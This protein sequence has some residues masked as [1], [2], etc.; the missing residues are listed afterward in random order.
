MTDIDKNG[1]LKRNISLGFVSK[2]ASVI[3]S[4]I[5]VK[6]YM[7][8]LGSVE[9]GVWVTLFSFLSWL[10]M[11]DLGV[12]NGL[13]INL[14][15]YL[16]QNKTSQARDYIFTSYVMIF[17]IILV[18]TVFVFFVVKIFSISDFLEINN[19]TR[20]NVDSIFLLL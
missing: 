13:K 1:I 15:K 10:Y 19:K 2:V 17:L 6:V 5:S 18:L 20:V 8:N 3:V 16:S 11:A 9:Y 14:T 12:G 4:F 7:D